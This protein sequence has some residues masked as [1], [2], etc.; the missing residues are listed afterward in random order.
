MQTR[1]KTEKLQ[2]TFPKCVYFK[3][4]LACAVWILLEEHGKKPVSP[5]ALAATWE[6]ILVIGCGASRT[7]LRTV[8]G[9][10]DKNAGTISWN[11]WEFLQS[12]A[13]YP[14]KATSVPR[15][16]QRASSSLHVR[17]EGDH[18]SL[19]SARYLW[20]HIHVTAVSTE[21]VLLYYCPEFVQCHFKMRGIRQH[22]L[23]H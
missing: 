5:T 3:W 8:Y 18:Y 7:R 9:W 12:K 6:E 17:L 20:I 22:C 10:Q 21:T 13:K 4:V 14:V 19:L 23:Q 11:Q 16:S 2:S 1:R 15:S